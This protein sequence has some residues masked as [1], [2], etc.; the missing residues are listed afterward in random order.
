MTAALMIS[1]VICQAS[2]WVFYQ[3][4][5]L[6]EWLARTLLAVFIIALCL[7]LF[8]SVNEIGGIQNNGA[9]GER[10]DITESSNS[11]VYISG[12]VSY[13]PMAEH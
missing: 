1:F 2:L 4:Y 7:F 5:E 3:G 8:M 6:P 11:S 9:T 13:P 12:R 10:R